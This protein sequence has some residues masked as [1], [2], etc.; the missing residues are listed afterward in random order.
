MAV[1]QSQLENRRPATEDNSSAKPE[2][3]YYLSQKLVDKTRGKTWVNH[4][5]AL[6]KWH[7]LRSKKGLMQ[8]SPCFFWM[9]KLTD[10]LVNFGFG[11]EEGDLC[12]LFTNSAEIAAALWWPG[13][14]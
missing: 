1:A 10:I 3:P 9:C 5:L 14:D 6:E 7:A 8:M 13:I 4:G 12:C 2:R 11:W